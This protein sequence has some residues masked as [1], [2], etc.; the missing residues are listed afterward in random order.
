MVDSDDPKQLLIEAE[1]MKKL[2]FFGVAVSTAATLVAIICVPMLCTY[3]QSVQSNLQDEI[4]FCKTRA[5]GLREEF[6]KVRLLHF[7]FKSMFQENFTHTFK[8]NFI[9]NFNFLAKFSSNHHVQRSQ[10]KGKRGKQYFN[11]AAVVLVQLVHQAR[12]DKMVIMDKMA[13]LVSLVCQVR[14]LKKMN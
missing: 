1:S 2:A 3:M 5:L 14:M 8:I 11:A 9:E 12:L 6:T 7:F 4:R 10:T 13:Y